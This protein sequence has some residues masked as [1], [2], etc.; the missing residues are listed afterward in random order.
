MNWNEAL[1]MLRYNLKDNEEYL[2]GKLLEKGDP[3]Y[4]FS[5]E[6]QYQLDKLFYELVHLSRMKP[7]EYHYQSEA[8][9]YSK[10][11]EHN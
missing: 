2:E 6:I 1:L 5:Y 8:F 10:E 4:P 3:M 9:N 11:F 7:G